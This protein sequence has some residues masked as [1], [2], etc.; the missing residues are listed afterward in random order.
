MTQELIPL[1]IATI[2]TE[3]QKTVNARDLHAFLEVKS[4]F[5][6]WII[7]RIEGVGFEEGKDFVTLTKNLVSG[8]K[9]KEYYVSV[10]MAKELAMLERNEKGKQARL[11]FIECERV[12][13]EKAYFGGFYIPKTLPDALRLAANLADKNEQLEKQIEGARPKVAFTDSVTSGDTEVTI[14]VAAKT[15]GI[16]PRK[17][18]DWLRLNGFL[19]KQANQ[20]TQYA[21]E[22]GY[23]VTRFAKITH[24]DD[25]VEKKPYPHITGKGLFYFYGRLLKEG[26]IVKND[27]LELAA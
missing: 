26:L 8:G 24:D 22:K 12:A 1:T 6:D 27:N 2:G 19:Y 10:S 9:S 16:G 15:L 25:S 20:A 11:Y 5:N 17:F 3:E 13:K 18:F 7:N 4:R 21:I 14:T 23:M